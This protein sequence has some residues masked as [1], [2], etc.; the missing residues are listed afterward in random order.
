MDIKEYIVIS[1]KTLRLYKARSF[2]T[3]LGIIVGVSS[4][5][6]LIS[7]G[8]GARLYVRD[9]F[10]GMGSNL[11]IITPGKAETTGRHPIIGATKHILRYEDAMVLKRR[12]PGLR[13]LSPVILGSGSVKFKNKKR[14]TT[15]LGV[16]GEFPEVRNIYV[17]IGEFISEEDVRGK[18]NVAVLGRK[19]KKEL[20]G[21]KNPLGEFVIVNNRRFRVIGIMER[22][23]V[24]LGFD[25]DDVI[26][27]PVKTAEKIFNSIALFEIIVSVKNEKDMNNIISKI[28]MVL[29]KRHGNK[30]DFTINTQAAILESLDSIIKSLTYMLG[31]IA[32]ISL[33]V[34]GIGIMNIMLV[35]VKER[36]REIGIRKAVGA[37]KKDILFQFLF[38]SAL[39]SL[40]GGILGVI[41]GSG[42]AKF[43]NIIIPS[44]PIK[45]SLWSIILSVGFSILI[46][47]FF[48][49]YPAKKG[50][51]LDP[52][53][54]LRYE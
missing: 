1:S 19:V 51:D 33:V 10:T 6:L 16:N 9:V 5:I 34:G 43:I 36:T 32:A 35:S 17:E 25:M 8:E 54:A 48:G 30:E 50:A 49:V 24:T 31:G 45:V 4:V 47:I 37:K 41:I 42:F 40:L 39:L 18:R 14:D 15:I 22:K 13:G 28:K 11:L 27:I 12:V 26:F 52:V 38:E 46:G 29:K 23:G 2:L 3:M 7:L 20:F 53:L 44:L 21:L